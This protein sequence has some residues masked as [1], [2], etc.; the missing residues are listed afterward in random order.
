MSPSKQCKEAGLKNMIEMVVIS[1]KPRRTL[2]G[3]HKSNPEFFKV[4]LV[5]CVAVKNER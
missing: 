2:E 4:I 5:G 3:W 1:N